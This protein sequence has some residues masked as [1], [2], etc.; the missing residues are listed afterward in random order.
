MNFLNFLKISNINKETSIKIFNV[1]GQLILSKTII[2]DTE[3]KFSLENGVYIIKINS[4]SNQQ[5]IKKLI[6]TN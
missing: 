4:Q 1:V 6:V 3:I 5:L 2:E